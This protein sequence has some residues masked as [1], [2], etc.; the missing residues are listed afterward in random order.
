MEELRPKWEAL[1]GK[2]PKTAIEGRLGYSGGE[3][4]GDAR[5]AAAKRFPEIARMPAV[6]ALAHDEERPRRRAAVSSGTL[7]RFPEAARLRT[8]DGRSS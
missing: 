1:F 6:S 3:M 7:D 4:S 5:R 2:L 8:A